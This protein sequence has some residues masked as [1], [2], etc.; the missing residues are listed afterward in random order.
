[1]ETIQSI[2]NNSSTNE[3]NSQKKAPI[4]FSILD[5]RQYGDTWIHILE[6]QA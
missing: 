5:C 2:N 6:K 3:E 4:G 1:M